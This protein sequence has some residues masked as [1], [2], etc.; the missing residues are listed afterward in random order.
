MTSRRFLPDIPF[1]PYSFVPGRSP[2][3]V[4][5]PAGHQYGIAPSSVEPID[6]DNWQQ[7]R[8]YLRAIDLFNHGFYWE[9][10]EAWERLWHAAGRTGSLA[11][12]L[13]GLIKLAAAGVKVREGK[14]RGVANHAANAAALFLQVD[15]DRFLGLSPR[16]LAVSARQIEAQAATLRADLDAPVVV[17]FEFVLSPEEGIQ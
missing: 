13:K 3:P 4:S 11:D 5:D 16:D 8:D 15:G 12:F 7:S 2:H 6:P 9:A 10:H 14:P 17:V 1:P